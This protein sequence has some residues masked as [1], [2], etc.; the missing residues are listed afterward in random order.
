MAWIFVIPKN[1]FPSS[2]P[3]FS[4]FIMIPLLL[5]LLISFPTIQC[6]PSQQQ[7][8]EKSRD[9]PD[10]TLSTES[11]SPPPSINESIDESSPINASNASNVSNSAENVISSS[12]EKQTKASNN[13]NLA[14]VDVASLYT[15]VQDKLRNHLYHSGK[16]L[17]TCAAQ[18]VCGAIFVR[19]NHTKRL[20]D[21][22]TSND[23]EC[24]DQPTVYD[25]HTIE[26][27]RIYDRKVYTQ[28]KICEP[29]THVRTCRSP[30]DWTLLALQ[31]ERTGKAHYVVVCRCPGKLEGPYTHNYPPYARIPGIKVYGMLCVQTTA[32]RVSKKE[33]IANEGNSTEVAGI[34]EFPWDHA[35][36]VLNSTAY[37]D[38]WYDD[39]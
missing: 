38:Y 34:P 18:Q 31:S 4:V 8:Q 21:C 23:W 36:A 22:P 25:G 27:T 10:F 12:Y 16:M 26:L 37:T 39:Y 33:K 6:L 15:D 32:T 7:K 19:M 30:S 13:K 28:V 5:Q 1:L 2:L 11:P 9:V 35:Y 29:L 3:S 14:Y 20:C 24:N 17:P